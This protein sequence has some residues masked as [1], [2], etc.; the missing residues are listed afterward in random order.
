MRSVSRSSA[1]GLIL[2]TQ[3][4]VD[5]S[6]V[7]N[8]L[9]GFLLVGVGLGF[10]FVPVSIAALSGIEP[11]GG[12]ARVGL[13]NTSQQIG[14][15]LGVA[16]LTTVFTTRSTNLIEDGEPQPDAFVSGFSAAF[17]VAA[18]S[19]GISIVAT[20]V[21][22]RR[23]DL[24]RRRRSGRRV[25]GQAGKPEGGGYQSGRSGMTT[26]GLSADENAPRDGGSP[27]PVAHQIERGV[28]SHVALGLEGQHQLG[29]ARSP[30]GP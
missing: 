8:L 20:L 25:G 9:P 15:A 21:L 26:P 16:I 23:S 19:L 1:A 6:Y 4:P 29:V 10:S 24:Q 2:F 13:I 14:G 12:G 5:G 27:E 17:W 3:I 22:L 7:T 28:E 30:R 18:R 11:Q